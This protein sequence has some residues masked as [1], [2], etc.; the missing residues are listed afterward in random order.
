MRPVGAWIAGP[1]ASSVAVDCKRCAHT[2]APSYSPFNN[3]FDNISLAARGVFSGQFLQSTVL[4]PL[5]IKAPPR[6]QT[7]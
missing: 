6:R 5:I 7:N 1:A 4:N 3:P 2:H